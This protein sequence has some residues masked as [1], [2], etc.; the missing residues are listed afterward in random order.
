MSDGPA[1]LAPSSDLSTRQDDAIRQS[2]IPGIWAAL[3]SLQFILLAG[4]FPKT[5]WVAGTAF[6]LGGTA[7]CLVKLYLVL[8]KDQI[9]P[10]HPRRWRLAFCFSL[11]LYSGVWGFF[12]AASNI[13]NGY[14]N[15]SSLL[16]MFCTLAASAG[17]LI[18]Q[19]P[20]LSF[21]YCHL[22]PLI[23]PS[24]AAD[25][26]IGRQ[27]LA[28]AC[29]K[30]IYLLFLFVQ[31]RHLNARFIEA[32]ENQRQLEHAKKMAEAADEAKSSFLANMSHELRTP[33]NGIIGMTELVLDTDLSE[34]QRDLLV[35]AR[36]SALSLLE[37][38]ND[39]LDFSKVEA[40][41]LELENIPFQPRNLIVESV[42]VLRPQAN[43][44]GL[45]LSYEIGEEV[46]R[47]VLGDPV[48]LRQ[49][50][51]NLV[52][53]AIKFTHAGRVAVSLRGEVNEGKHSWLHF[54]ITDT[55]I[56]IAK[57]KHDLIFQPFV[58]ADL[59]MTRKYGG[60][61]LGLS[62]C[63]RLIELMDG[64]IWLESE[65]GRGSTFHFRVRLHAYAPEQSGSLPVCS[66]EPNEDATAVLADPS[67]LSR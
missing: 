8:R 20:R 60:T 37:L 64:T 43:Q 31:G 39:V 59:S 27:A 57:E 35:T 38:L 34:E 11:L 55:G 47:T 14:F 30:S 3:G 13:V 22:L 40:R 33:M 28:F 26:W 58:Q 4:A 2:A 1:P 23:V 9:Y 10:A 54:Q 7:A 50:L 67:S 6:A 53:N 56:G 41:R 15:W 29:I 16:L 18:S 66:L 45:E 24:I 49:V 25:L 12:S 62:I 61:G 48:R 44:K 52:G 32:L 5:D 17:A 36:R 65:P 46:P 21:L 63:A 42:A 19:T 51:I